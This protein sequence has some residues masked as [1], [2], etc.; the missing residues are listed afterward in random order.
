MTLEEFKNYI[1]SLDDDFFVS[2]GNPFSQKE[3]NKIQKRM[4][5]KLPKDYMDFLKFYGSLYVEVNENSWPRIR[6]ADFNSPYWFVQY[7]VVAMG[8]GKDTPDA[9]N[10]EN[11]YYSFNNKYNPEMSLL[12][13]FMEVM[14]TQYYYCLDESGTVYFW[15]FDEPWPKRISRNYFGQLFSHI[16]DLEKNK[17]YIANNRDHVLDLINSCNSDMPNQS[18]GPP[19]SSG[20]GMQEEI[21]RRTR[22]A[23]LYSW[24]EPGGSS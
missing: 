10:A 7:G 15:A 20:R 4:G 9:H 12:P 3:I 23:P 21:R 14:V 16:N 2:R 6:N 17:N 19:E 22:E 18:G 13:I 24:R 8:L 11:C 1:D 5:F